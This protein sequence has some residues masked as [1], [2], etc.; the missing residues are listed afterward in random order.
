MDANNKDATI[1]ANNLGYYNTVY[2]AILG[3][4]HGIEPP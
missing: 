2:I 3:Q 1:A 4:S